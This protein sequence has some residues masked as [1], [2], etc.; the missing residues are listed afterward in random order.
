MLIFLTIAL[1]KTV[2]WQPMDTFSDVKDNLRVGL[3]RIRYLDGDVPV[4][5]V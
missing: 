1:M 4:R 5:K 3:I 2:S